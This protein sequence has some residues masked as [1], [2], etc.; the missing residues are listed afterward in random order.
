LKKFFKALVT[1]LI[2]SAIIFGGAYLLSI[3]CAHITW[4]E[5]VLDVCAIIVFGWLLAADMYNRIWNR[6]KGA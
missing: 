2:T 6:K 5:A 4:L 1:I 3:A